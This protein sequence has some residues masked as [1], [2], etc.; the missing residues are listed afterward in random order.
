MVAKK[1]LGDDKITA[2]AKKYVSWV[3]NVRFR[4]E[5]YLYCLM[6]YFAFLRSVSINIYIFCLEYLIVSLW[7][8]D[9]L[10][11]NFLGMYCYFSV[12]RLVSFIQV[13]VI[14]VAL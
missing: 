12:I 6:K 5:K 3:L 1:L 7:A 11:T 4:I 2:F 14:V 9:W 13:P 8:V 10:T